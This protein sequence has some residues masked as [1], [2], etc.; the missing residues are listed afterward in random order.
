VDSRNTD[1]LQIKKYLE[2]KL[3]ARAMYELE[4]RALDD[5]FLMDAMEGYEVAGKRDNVLDDLHGTL[6]NR[7]HNRGRVVS[8]RT[9][10]IAAS[11]IAV[12]TVGGWWLFSRQAVDK[13][14]IVA[15]TD[16]DHTA[17]E[18]SPLVKEP[19]I[20]INKDSLLALNV[21]KAVIRSPR[22]LSTRVYREPGAVND[23]A[24]ISDETAERALAV[25]Q[26]EGTNIAEVVTTNA[27]SLAKTDSVPF[28]EMVVMGYAAR[29]KR[30]ATTGAVLKEVA[31]APAKDALTSVVSTTIKGKVVGDDG[32]PLPGVAVS[33]GNSVN[34]ALTDAN[35]NYSL[36][37][38]SLKTDLT[39]NYI[40][41]KTRKLDVANGN[42]ANVILESQNAGL[43]EV[44][45]IGYGK[46]KARNAQPENGWENFQ[47]YL[48]D[49]AISADVTGTYRVSFTV[50]KDGSLTGFSVNKDVNNVGGQKAIQ[51]IKDGPEW[52]GNSN[53]KPKRVTVSVRFRKQESK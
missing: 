17:V 20:A 21:P 50:E 52:L 26:Q 24:A 8:M 33:A 22:R 23:V 38:D 3:D 49:N 32:Q 51:L 28:N 18:P 46:A 25:T 41:Y 5:P 45:V 30:S 13:S 37:I 48:N 19:Q 12:L 40:G 35:G 47:K 34:A 11:V 15:Q 16:P 10:T 7:S 4:R 42:T 2:G 29:S 6:Q 53:G 43:N 39:Y 31:I 1:I 27:R 44:V 9:L 14:Q 36:N